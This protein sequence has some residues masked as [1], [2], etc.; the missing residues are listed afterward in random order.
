MKTI[1]LSLAIL[2]VLSMTGCNKKNDP[3]DGSILGEGTPGNTLT[4]VNKSGQPVYIYDWDMSLEN[5]LPISPVPGGNPLNSAQGG[6][7]GTLLLTMQK[8]S[9]P[10][11]AARRIYISDTELNKSLNNPSTPAAPD[12]FNY[13]V[14]ATAQYT[15]VEYNYNDPSNPTSANSY[16]IDLSYIDEYSYPV[17][18][19]FSNVGTYT[20]CEEGHEYGFTSMNSVKNELKS[21]SPPV[22][23]AEYAWD[24]LIWPEIVNC[25]WDSASYPHGM[26]RIIGPN[27]VWLQNPGSVII[28]NWVPYSYLP[29]IQSL[30]G[31]GNQLFGGQG[32]TT[33]NWTGW[34]NWV[35]T[36][37]PSPSNTGYVKALHAAANKD[38]NGKYGFFCYPNDN[39]DGEFTYVPDSVKCT[40]TVYS[41]SN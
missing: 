41:L 38:K 12:P 15:F 10:S 40:V 14:D 35:Y 36:H 21:I 22:S 33:S 19:K 1:T 32:S 29:F 9:R 34:E 5:P 7:G 16:T 18:L 17:T 28:G 11:V 13:H 24:A 2:I 25:T 39:T 37:N 30:P 3:A 6:I 8:A 23:G 4:I 20:G 26:V 31:T 27:K